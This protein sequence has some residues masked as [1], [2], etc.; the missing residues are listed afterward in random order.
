MG[1]DHFTASKKFGRPWPPN[2]LNLDPPIFKT[3]YAYVLSC[4]M[5]INTVSLV[6]EFSVRHSLDK[7]FFCNFADAYINVCSFVF[8][9]VKV[10][11]RMVCQSSKSPYLVWSIPDKY[12]QKTNY[13]K[14][15]PKNLT[16][17]VSS[18]KQISKF[19]RFKKSCTSY[20]WML[21]H[22]MHTSTYSQGFVSMVLC[23]WQ[24]L[25]HDRQ[26]FHAPTIFQ[27]HYK[28]TVFQQKLQTY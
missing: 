14:K 27:W 13:M 25:S 1:S 16:C 5:R 18:V 20:V 23:R 2:S 28:L 22:Y 7:I 3:V 21:G 24:A 12:Y 26:N 6:F 19:V 8:V 4:L 9:R 17:K 10:F 11:C 15:K